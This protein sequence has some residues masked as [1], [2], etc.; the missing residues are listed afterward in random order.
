[1]KVTM[2]VVV[3]NDTVRCQWYGKGGMQDE[4]FLETDLELS[5][6]EASD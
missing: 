2:L 6:M 4:A 1:M 3:N 5:N